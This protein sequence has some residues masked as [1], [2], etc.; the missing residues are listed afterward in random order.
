MS[1]LRKRT[2]GKGTVLIIAVFFAVCIALVLSLRSGGFRGPP[3][4]KHVLLIV[5]DTLRSNRLGC[6]GYPRPTSPN[7]DRLAAR[8]ALYERNYS[9][10]CWTLPSMI[11]MM[12]GRSV[13]DEVK[14]LPPNLPVLAETMRA[15]GFETA[16]FIANA[17]LGKASG[18]SR[19][20]DA[21]EAPGNAR[22]GEVA[23]RFEAWSGARAR[24]KPFFAWVQFI[25]P[26][27]PYEPEPAH[28][29]FQ[30]PRPDQEV[31]VRRWKAA[32]PRL[33]ELSPDPTTPTL[34]ASIEQA[35]SESNRYDGEVLAVDEGVGRILAALE[36]SGELADTLVILASDHGEMLY[37]HPQQPLI[38]DL[39]LKANR[40]LPAG[41]LDLFGQGHRPW[42]FED[43]WRTP[44]IL[45][46]PGIPAGARRSFLSANLDIAS[47][48]LD[49][50][51]LDS[52]AEYEGHSLWRDGDP[53]RDR[54][55]AHGHETSAVVESRGS[56]LFVHPP[57][58]FLKPKTDPHLLE[59]HDLAVDP[60]EDED[61]AEKRPEERDRLS[62]EVAGWRARS[63]HFDPTKV[64]AEQLKALQKFGYTDDG[65]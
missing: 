14:A 60:L 10:A 59:L 8:G 4:P 41:V 37:E 40:K 1:S 3:R 49:A 17:V 23:N 2:G 29:V 26:H 34:E 58:L 56:K 52:P 45:A 30:G 46:G 20:F 53:G 64:S 51:G 24:E 61:F 13:V 33:A 62:K 7:I 21:Y 38:V 12:S 39:V 32:M 27:H 11:S 16:G 35:T 19:G 31:L 65:E 50:V 28:D 48:I 25:D 47:T 15:G 42:Y 54:V 36:K 22:A 6:Y 63:P 44:L 57:R 55:F 9:Q 5:A 43:L 18:F